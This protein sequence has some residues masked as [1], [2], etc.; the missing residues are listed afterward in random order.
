MPNQEKLVFIIV[1]MPGKD[2]GQFHQV[3]FLA[4]QLRYDLWSPV[5]PNELELLG[6]KDL[7]HVLH[8]W[9]CVRQCIGSSVRFNIETAQRVLSDLS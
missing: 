8:L 3:Q 4:I 7:F 6:Q 2:A 1:L 9:V 5:F